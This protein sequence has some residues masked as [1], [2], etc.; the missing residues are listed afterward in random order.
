MGDGGVTVTQA[1]SQTPN[2][3]DITPR[4]DG[5][6]VT[7]QTSVTDTAGLGSVFRP[8]LAENDEFFLS[9]GEIGT[10]RV[11]T[12]E[13]STFLDMENVP[14]RTTDDTLV[15]SYETTPSELR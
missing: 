2:L 9:S 12:E 5:F 6:D 8:L 10:F 1:A 7:I 4:Q 14:V 11:S 13:L 3:L 15:W